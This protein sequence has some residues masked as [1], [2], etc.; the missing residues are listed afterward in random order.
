MPIIA[1]T[2]FSELTTRMDAEY[3]QPLF[4][5][6][7]RTLNQ[8]SKN[9]NFEM[10][11]LETVSSSIRKGIFSISKTE[12]KEKGIAFIRVSD[13]GKLMIDKDN[14]AYIS[15]DL[16]EKEKKTCLGSRDIV[17]SKGGTLGQV[18]IIS[19]T[20]P[21]VNISQDVIG[22]RVKIGKVV[23]EYLS[24]YLASKFGKSWFK[25]NRSQQTHPHL[26]LQPVRELRIPIPSKEH[27][28]KVA[29]MVNEAIRLE[30][31]AD[32]A[33]SEADE[34]FRGAIGLELDRKERKIQTVNYSDLIKQGRFDAEFFEP[35]YINIEKV[36]EEKEN[37]GNLSIR[38]LREIGTILK[39]I[40]VGSKSYHRDEEGYVFL[41][42]SNLSEYGT[43][44]GGSARYIGHRLYEELAP[45]FQPK[46]GE[47][48][49]S[50]DGTIG[51]SLV[52]EDDFPHSI[53]SALDLMDS[54]DKILKGQAKRSIAQTSEYI[55]NICQKKLNS[56]EKTEKVVKRLLL[57]DR[58]HASHYSTIKAGEVRILGFKVKT[59]T[60]IDIRALHTLYRQHHFCEHDPS[61]IIEYL[62]GPI[63]SED[64]QEKET[65]LSEMENEQREATAKK[66]TYFKF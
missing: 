14:L 33:R 45:K 5:K 44:I 25:R 49:Y 58:V 2:S 26:E 17:I 38:K 28:S 52:V 13:I 34:V 48:I 23:P 62:P 15:E 10:A 65:E 24:V 57:E 6:M 1:E 30:N 59:E 46:K 21:K 32:Q 63:P 9:P 51:I 19:S 11:R 35:R 66:V 55:K 42:V 56:K 36:L 40:E 22:V 50:K 7:E 61:T 4:L 16:N 31:E 29:I 18:A 47:L 27:Q 12:Y 60:Q 8:L 20:M 54:T 39:G 41:R 37:E 3:Y 53:I 43:R 64:K